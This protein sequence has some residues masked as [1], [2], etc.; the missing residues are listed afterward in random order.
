MNARD[1]N[2][3]SLWMN[4]EVAPDAPRL[5]RDEKADVAIIGAGIAGLSI[6]YELAGKGFDVVIVDR[7]A[8]AGGMTARTSA[9]LTSMSDDG[10]D[11]VIRVRGLDGAKTYHTSHAAAIDRI[12]NIQAEESVSCNF[13]RV[14]GYL[15]PSP[16]MEPRDLDPELEATRKVGMEIHRH[17]GLPFRGL[18]EI[19]CL[20]YPHQATFHPLRYLRGVAKSLTERGARLYANS[21]VLEIVEG[22]SGVD[23]RTERGTITAEQAV[24]ATNSPIND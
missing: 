20:R 7:G 21:P 2:S 14:S 12:E 17:K 8:I 6:A 4:V 5:A 3:E 23:I 24:V 19:G 16:N 15:F 13:R 22:P 9:H 10:F 1:E 18:S 11:S